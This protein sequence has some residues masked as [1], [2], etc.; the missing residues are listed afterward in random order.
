MSQHGSKLYIIPHLRGI[1][2][3]VINVSVHYLKTF[4]LTKVSNLYNALTFKT[5]SG[6]MIV[7][8]DDFG[9]QAKRCLLFMYLNTLTE[10]YECH[11][12]VP[13][14]KTQCT[15]FFNSDFVP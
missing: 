4:C 3:S 12:T 15:F 2:S 7:W 8:E 5:W 14:S 1:N 10:F 11:T 9:P 6:V 13:C